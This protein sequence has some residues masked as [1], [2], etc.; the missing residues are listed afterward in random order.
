MANG[1]LPLVQ[2]PRPMRHV[3]A[4]LL[5]LTVTLGCSA[6]PHLCI[7]SPERAWIPG[8]AFPVG[9]EV[10][11]TAGRLDILAECDLPADFP[12]E[13]TSTAPSVASI[14]ANGLL[15]PLSPG[16]VEV[17]ARARGA[18]QRFAL[19]VTPTVARIDI[20]PDDTTISAG[21][22]VRFRAVAYGTDGSAL[23]DA[24][25]GMSVSDDSESYPGGAMPRGIYQVSAPVYTTDSIRVYAR[26]TGTRG[27][28]T[29]WVVGRADTLRI[30][31]AP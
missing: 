28:V 2:P 24:V 29:A 17:I 7:R 26:R 4:A 20:L 18:E 30:R 23:S 27:L 25:I 9:T 22:T 10:R 8:I 15:R 16:K 1:A 11:F 13:W 12:V 19:T 6:S 14:D 5:A 21:D 31:V 3:S